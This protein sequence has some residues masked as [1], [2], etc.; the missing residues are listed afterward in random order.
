MFDL[1]WSRNAARFLTLESTT[2][3]QPHTL[4]VLCPMLRPQNCHLKCLDVIAQIQRRILSVSCVLPFIPATQS[5]DSR[6]RSDTLRTSRAARGCT[7]CSSILYLSFRIGRSLPEMVSP[8]P[9][10]PKRLC[11]QLAELT[12]HVMRDTARGSG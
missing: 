1:P 3:Q 5:R 6:V 9:E 10:D 7:A 12:L 4:P 2:E 8:V 11:A